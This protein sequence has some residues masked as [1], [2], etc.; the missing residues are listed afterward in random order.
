M[1]QKFSALKDK[2]VHDPQ[3]SAESSKLELSL[4]EQW[5][6]LLVHMENTFAQETKQLVSFNA[7]YHL[8]LRFQFY[9]CRRFHSIS[10]LLCFYTFNFS[11]LDCPHSSRIHFA[12]KKAL[13]LLFGFPWNL[14][15]QM[16]AS[17][18]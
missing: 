11:F 3:S 13:N 12:H 4:M 14:L 8:G 10:N 6:S 5:K 9:S 7:I 17:F 1:L 18:C 15:L 16:E 2:V